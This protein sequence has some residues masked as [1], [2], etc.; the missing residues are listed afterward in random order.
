MIELITL[1]IGFGVLF[2]FYYRYEKR[3]EIINYFPKFFQEVYNNIASGMSLVEAVR[4][5]KESNYG[6]LTPYIRNM[7]FQIEWG[8][9][10]QVAIRNFST[11]IKDSFINKV[12]T[13]TEKAFQFSPDI[14]KSIKEINEYILLTKE[15]EKERHTEIFPQIISIYFIFFVF[16]FVI[17]ILFNYFIPLLVTDITFYENIFKHLILIEATLTGL[18]LG[19]ISEGSYTAGIKHLILLGMVSI[20]FLLAI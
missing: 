10:F 1:I 18:I 2:Y 15:L 3:K 12:V 6:S 5:S 14:G 16:L 11:Q 7:C 20:I 9:P 19:K 8:I 4:K 13:L 17:Y